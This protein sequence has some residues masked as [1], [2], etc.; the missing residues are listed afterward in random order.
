MKNWKILRRIN[1]AQDFPSDFD[2]LA[3]DN[4][5]ISS[6]ISALEEHPAIKRVTS[7]RMVQRKIKYTLTDELSEN[8]FDFNEFRDNITEKYSYS[9][10]DNCEFS[11]C[12]FHNWRNI[13]RGRSIRSY[14]SQ[15]DQVF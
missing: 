11:T 6:S 15:F 13:H 3:F 4:D 10:D 5:D 9:D 1:P 12:L 7:Q 2:I 14:S 8:P